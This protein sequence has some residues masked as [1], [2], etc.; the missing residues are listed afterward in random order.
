MK[1][2][3]TVNVMGTSVLGTVVLVGEKTCKVQLHETGLVLNYGRA[4]LEPTR[5][6]RCKDCGKTFEN[7]PSK[8]RPWTDHESG[9]MGWFWR[10]DCGAIIY[11][12]TK[13][14]K[15]RQPAFQ[16]ALHRAMM[17]GPLN[18]LPDR[19]EAVVERFMREFFIKVR[20]YYAVRIERRTKYIKFM[21]GEQSFAQAFKDMEKFLLTERRS[22][23]RRV[24]SAP[25][26]ERTRK[27]SGAIR[28]GKAPHHGQGRRKRR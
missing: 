28:T 6:N 15:K 10:C 13:E 8:A 25:N 22:R 24:N 14:N 18:Q 5:E 9:L 17:L 2:G 26:G 3:Q 19:V 1:I 27:N 12:E 7:I 16:T 4:Q 23:G 21:N 20:I 11:C